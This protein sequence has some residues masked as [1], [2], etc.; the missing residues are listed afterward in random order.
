MTGFDDKIGACKHVCLATMLWVHMQEYRAGSEVLQCQVPSSIV[1]RVLSK[2]VHDGS[3]VAASNLLSS[4]WRWPVHEWSL[5][6]TC[7]ISAHITSFGSPGRDKQF[8]DQQRQFELCHQLLHWWWCNWWAMWK[9]ISR[10]L[11]VTEERKKERKKELYWWRW[12]SGSFDACKSC[13][14]VG[15]W[16]LPETQLLINFWLVNGYVC[17]NASNFGRGACHWKQTALIKLVERAINNQP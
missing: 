3:H 15:C 9:I 14:W 13:K 5:L 8:G 16:M 11:L 7:G 4:F 2:M 12:K 6:Y 1:E 10:N 17:R